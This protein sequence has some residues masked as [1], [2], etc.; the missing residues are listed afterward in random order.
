MDLSVVITHHTKNR[1]LT[2][3]RSVLD[4]VLSQSGHKNIEVIVVCNPP[5]PQEAQLRA[6]YNNSVTVLA[7]AGANVN[8]ARNL[9]LK[10][11]TGETVL[12][13]DDDC[14]LDGHGSLEEITKIFQADNE[15]AAFGGDVRISANASRWDHAYFNVQQKWIRRAKQPDGTNAYLFGGFLA[16]R[17]SELK[18]IDFDEKI[19]FGGSEIGLLENL[20]GHT[21]DLGKKITW[22]NQITVL[23]K[24]KLTFWQFI[25]RAFKQGRNVGNLKR[26]NTAPVCYAEDSLAKPEVSEL[27]YSLFYNLG[28]ARSSSQRLKFILY[29]RTLQDFAIGC[30]RTLRW[31]RSGLELRVLARVQRA[32]R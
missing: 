19:K 15:L 17:A 25:S 9:G 7:S 6:L 14:I 23:H 20:R 27:I 10:A 29:L 4:S 18:N 11:A 2:V 28:K 30:S 21:K 26:N 22:S 24:S 13:L 16:A 8:R 1:D 31:T 12:F 3:L 5:S 32:L